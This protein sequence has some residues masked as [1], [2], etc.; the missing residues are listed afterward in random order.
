MH[1]IA[2]A[3]IATGLVLILTIVGAVLGG[4]A[5]DISAYAAAGAALSGL[6]IVAGLAVLERSTFARTA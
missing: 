4:A 1:R 6:V 5:M 2:L 3:L